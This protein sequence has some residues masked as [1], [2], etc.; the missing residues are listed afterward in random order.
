M[1]VVSLGGVVAGVAIPVVAKSVI[2]GPIA[3]GN[4][5]ALIPLAA[6][7]LGLGL[8]DCLLAV[9]RRFLMASGSSGLERDLRDALYEH[10]QR[11]QVSYHDQ[12]QSR[13]LL[14]RAMGDI[15]MIRRFFAFGLVFLVVCAAQFALV[16]AM[17]AHL[18]LPLALLTAIAIA[19]IVFVSGAFRR[20]YITIARRVQ[21]QQGD[22]TTTIEEAAVGIRIV[23]AFR[24][25]PFLN[26]R[27]AEQ[28][29]ELRDTALE[30]VRVRS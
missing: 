10:L 29:A 28:A 11:L 26:R 1:I 27:F 14:S 6:L 15:S 18:Y 2:D 22:L 5:R 20:R 25:G 21:D 8:V 16:T 9:F 30:G 4:Q 24:Q 19:P 7:A 3:H 23:K 17:L 12:I 13:Q